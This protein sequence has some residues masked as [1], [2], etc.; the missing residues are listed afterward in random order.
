MKISHLLFL[1]VS[2]SL[3][4]FKFI[5]KNNSLSETFTKENIG[6]KRPGTGISPTRF[7]DILGRKSKSGLEEDVLLREEDI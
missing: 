1:L 2:I 3:F 6:C 4:S 7:E 5:S